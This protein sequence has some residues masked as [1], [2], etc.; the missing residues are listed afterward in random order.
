VN[1]ELGGNFQLRDFRHLAIWNED[2]R[3]IEMHL[4]ST[5]RQ[6]IEIPSASL[7]FRM[8]EGET[9]WTESSHKYSPDEPAQMAQRAG[10]RQ[11]AQ[12]TDHEWLFAQ[13]LWIV[14]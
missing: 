1:R 4:Q 7:Y 3:R 13:N 5:R 10:F 11:I 6:H 2:E 9:I 12:W 8:E 14:D